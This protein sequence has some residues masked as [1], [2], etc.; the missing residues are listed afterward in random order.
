MPIRVGMVSLGCSKNLVDS[1]R[2]LAKLRAHGYQL[3]TE[4]GEAEIAIVNTCGFIQSAKEEAIETILELGAL[5]Q[6]G[7]LKKIILTGCLTERY[8]EEAAEL[9]TEADAVI[10]IGDNRDIV[11]ILDHVL[12]GERVVRFGKKA[13]AELTGDRIISTLPFFAYL[14]IAEGCSNCCTYCAIP[15]IRGPYRSVPME[16]VLKEARWMAEH[17]VTEINVVAQDTTQYGVDLYGKSRLPELLRELCHIPG[18]RWVRVLYC[19]PE[20][21]TEELLDVF[22]EEPHMV[23][24]LDLPIQPCDGEIL[25]RMHRPGDE[26]TL[27]KLIAHIRERVPEITL[28]TTLITGFPGETKEQFNRLGDFVQDMQFDHLGCFAYSEEEG[29]KA[30]EF[31]DQVDEDVRAHRAEIIMEQQA[32]VSAAKNAAK[33]GTRMTAVMEGYDKYAGCYF[34]RTA[35]DAPDIDGKIFVRSENRL[36]MGQY[37]TV[38]V[39]DTLDYDLLA[40]EVTDESTQ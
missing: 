24:Y 32:E 2:M 21:I 1:E 9:F 12:A 33:V 23:P 14:K 36:R 26:E 8:R 22:V 17:H 35:A 27:R 18:I 3:V 39:F 31:E 20:R 4:P 34:G 37:I 38:E 11:D 16:D 25:K 30:A 29:T 28:R 7:T 15:Q 5:K 10:G 40:E 19:Y 13:D 6:D